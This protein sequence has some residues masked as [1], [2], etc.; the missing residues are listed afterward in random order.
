MTQTINTKRNTKGRICFVCLK[1]IHRLVI[2]ISTEQS[3]VIERNYVL[4]NPSQ[5]L[6][7]FWMDGVSFYFLLLCLG[8]RQSSRVNPVTKFYHLGEK[9]LS[10]PRDIILMA[11]FLS[12]SLCRKIKPRT[13]D[14]PSY[15]PRNH[16]FISFAP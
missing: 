7:Y 2:S 14:G 3:G 6:F 16:H 5:L 11:V 15:L 4:L 13:Y 1:D 10:F 8:K 9:G 12:P